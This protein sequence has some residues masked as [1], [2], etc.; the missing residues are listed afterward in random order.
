M[1]SGPSARV[2]PFRSLRNLPAS[3]GSDSVQRAQA[4]YDETTQKAAYHLAE[5][6]RL[7][8]QADRLFTHCRSRFGAGNGHL[9]SSPLKGEDRLLR[10]ILPRPASPVTE[11]L[12]RMNKEG[13]GHKQEAAPGIALTR[14]VSD[15]GGAP[16]S[17]STE[18][19]S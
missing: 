11:Y 16:N 8:E 19:K 3:A 12:K 2:P 1:R 13:V 4:L 7:T 9:K 15:D 6:V 18:T 17:R 10:S 14:P 5:A